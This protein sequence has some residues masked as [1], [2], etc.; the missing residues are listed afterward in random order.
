[1]T[2]ALFLAAVLASAVPVPGG[3]ESPPS[4]QAGNPDH[5]RRLVLAALDRQAEFDYDS[6]LVLLREARTAD[7]RDLAAHDH[8]I[9][10]TLALQ[11]SGVRD[12]RR[13]Y[14]SMPDSPLVECLRAQLDAA[15]DNEPAAAP[16]L[17]ELERRYPEEACPIVQLA[18]LLRDLK[19]EHEWKALRIDYLARAVELEPRLPYMWTSYA[20]ALASAGRF[21]D[22]ERAYA[23]AAAHLTHPLHAI[24][25]QMRRAGL[26]LDRGDVAGAESLRRAVEQAVERDGRPGIHFMYLLE[27]GSF[28]NVPASMLGSMDALLREQ[29]ELA[30]EFGSILDEWQVRYTL[31]MRLTNRGDPLTA[32][33]ELDRALEL[34][35]SSGVPGNQVRSLYKRAAAF[36]RAGQR[37]EAERDLL[38]AVDLISLDGSPY[39]EAETWHGLLHLYDDDGRLEEALDV[40]GRF[41]MTAERMT[42]SSLRVSA[43]LDAGELRWKARQHAA[44]SEAFRG[45]VEVVD[46]FDEYHAFAGQYFERIGD[47]A[48]AR[49]YYERGAR[50]SAASADGVRSLNW[51]GLA[52]VYSALG[53]L[54]SAEVV[55]RRHD[56]AIVI[57]SSAPLLPALLAERGRAEEAAETA[58]EWARKR[59]DAGAVE[60]AATAHLLWAEMLLAA[61]RPDDALEVAGRADSLARSIDRIGASAKAN[62]LRGHALEALGD[63]EGARTTLEFA[64]LEALRHGDVE[65][66][67]ETHLALGELLASEGRTADALDAFDTASRQAEATATSLDLDFD[68]VRY[69]SQ[70][71]A[72]YDAALI[73]LL[74]RSDDDMA[75]EVLTWSQR[76]KAASLRLAGG[77]G[78]VNESPE[79]TAGQGERRVRLDRREILLDYNVV[80]DLIFVLVVD[81]SGVVEVVRLAVS[82]DSV[83]SLVDQLG[84]PFKAVYAGSVDLARFR[85]PEATSRAIFDAIVAPVLP[86]IYGADRLLIAPDGPLHRVSFAALVTSGVPGATSAG[87]SLTKKPRFLVEDFEILYLP[88]A[89]VG[90]SPE[91]S[92]WRGIDTSRPVAVVVGDAPGTRQEVD[93]LVAVWPGGVLGAEV[94]QTTESALGSFPAAPAVLHV[95]SHAVADDRDSYASYIRL[96]PDSLSDGML[97]GAEIIGMDLTGSLIVLSA[98]ET[99]E[100]PLFAG[101]GLLGLQRSFQATGA[102]AVLATLWP[103]G[104]SAAELVEHF[105][106]RLVQGDSPATALRRA[107]LRMLEDPDTAHPFHWA[108]FVLHGGS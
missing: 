63:R 4:T 38:R 70:R 29:A 27:L 41:I 85:F 66:V 96:A 99:L 107:Q 91:R 81:P 105:Y 18:R 77:D 95:A 88:S 1:M 108:G 15:R 50:S 21:D 78:G 104:P 31:G 20:A 75:G 58:G 17:F 34:A 67:L 45:L 13:E 22:A 30:R 33:V 40:S 68:R 92:D 56:A 11:P 12:L 14:N 102:S 5:A 3:Q 42:H 83:R 76:R 100:G 7:P 53:A 93:N 106:E 87:S 39:N 80:G 103:V 16:A 55:A 60:G 98:C 37:D 25:L 19:P 89:G 8:L 97:H 90:R 28:T 48:T 86:A 52:R 57:H 23:A 26:L 43:W 46:D 47:L 73:A 71:L 6:A 35:D 49:T 69:R 74:G 36:V 32:L 62:L 84:S 64:A 9:W 59:L 101:E 79:V 82:P 94:S 54:D 65:T 44:A 10:L 72:P 24:P 61:N 51:A 2:P